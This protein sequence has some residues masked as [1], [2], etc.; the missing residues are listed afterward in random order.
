MPSSGVAEVVDHCPLLIGHPRHRHGVERHDHHVFVKH[1]VVL[2]V[3]PHRQRGG[4]GAA[5]EEHGGARNPQQRWP[6]V[7]DLLDELAQR[8]LGLLPFLGDDVTAALPRRHHRERGDGDQ[9]RQPGTVHQF[10]QVGREE[11]QVDEQQH[12]AAEYDQPQ[13]FSPSGAGEIEEQKGRDRDR[14]GDRHAERVG[15]LRRTAERE[16]QDQHR[17]H[18]HPVDPRHIDLADRRRRTCARRAAAAGNRAEP[19]ARP[20]RTRR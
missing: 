15:E 17:H 5:V 13:R 3:G 11:H 14:A 18:Q 12:A 1:V 8:S 6:V 2:D 7:R 20:P 19:P 9:Q 16:D 4:L 10:G